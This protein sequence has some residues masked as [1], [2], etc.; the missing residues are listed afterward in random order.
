MRL[1]IVALNCECSRGKTRVTSG[2]VADT[3]GTQHLTFFPK[4]DICFT[5]ILAECTQHPSYH[6]IWCFATRP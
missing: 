3:N 5:Y 1:F 4:T 6:Q 2:D